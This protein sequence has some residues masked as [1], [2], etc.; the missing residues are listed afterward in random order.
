MA[1]NRGDTD[2][3]CQPGGCDYRL[4]VR[5]GWYDAGDHGKYVVNGGI[6]VWHLL[7]LYERSVAMKREAAFTDGRAKIP[8]AGNRVPDLLDEAPGPGRRLRP[9]SQCFTGSRGKGAQAL[10][11]P[12]V[13]ED[14]RVRAARLAGEPGGR[15]GACHR[16]RRRLSHRPEDRPEQQVRGAVAEEVRRAPLGRPA[17]PARA[18]PLPH[19][20]MMEEGEV[21][22][23]LPSTMF[24]VQLDNGH[25]VLAR[26]SG[27]M[28]KH[29][30]RI[31]PGDRV[32]VELSPYDLT[33]GRITFR[34]K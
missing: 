5:G 33:R 6:S 8:E 25:A 4:D 13:G 9:P 7:A 28:R 29:Y 12:H 26:I 11:A 19:S 10:L 32:K 27:K 15:V 18:V 34:M 31:L 17:A 16:E 30:I 2:V 20:A 1:P 22:E 14:V 23:A 21:V 24:R 3:P